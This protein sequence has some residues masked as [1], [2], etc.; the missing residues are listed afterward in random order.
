MPAEPELSHEAEQATPN[1]E[2]SLTERIETGIA[3]ALEQEREVHLD[4]ARAIAEALGQAVGDDSVLARFADTGQGNYLALREE[5]LPLYSEPTTPAEVRHWIDWFGTFLVQRENTGSGRR[6]M[7]EHL[8]PVLERVLVRTV[9]ESQAGP[10]TV[11][12]PATLDAREIIA[13]TARLE[14]LDEFLGTSFK[15]FLTLSDVNAADP[16]L[17]ESY[18]ETYVG[19]FRTIEEALRALTPLEE[20]EAEL[21]TWAKAHGLDA[22]TVRIDLDAIEKTMRTMHDARSHRMVWTAPCLQQIEEPPLP[23]DISYA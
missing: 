5:Y 11:H 4:T 17:M 20:W 14:A 23:A 10:V 12:L 18:R 9:L 3:A 15:A 13:L 7:N 22:E 19:S 6:F 16:N 1:T 21:A 8:D 2:P